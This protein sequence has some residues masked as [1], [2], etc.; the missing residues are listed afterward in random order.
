MLVG[1]FIYRRKRLVRDESKNIS[2]SKDLSKLEES[3]TVTQLSNY[4]HDSPQ[5]TKVRNSDQSFSLSILSSVDSVDVS[6]INSQKPPRRFGNQSL[7]SM[8]F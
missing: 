7:R 6:T 3:D 1:A 8:Q 5:E 2:Q 4:K